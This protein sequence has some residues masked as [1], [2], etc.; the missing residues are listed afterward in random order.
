M[1]TNKTKQN[2][3]SKQVKEMIQDLKI[4]IEIVKKPQTE[5]ILEMENLSK[6]IGAID[7]NIMNRKQ[8]IKD[9]ISC[10]EDAIE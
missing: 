5:E 9:R 2:Q 1:K 3:K 7:T 4:K 10:T 6:W 8:K